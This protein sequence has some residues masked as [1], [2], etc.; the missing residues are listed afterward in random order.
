[1]S[2]IYEYECVNRIKSL[3]QSIESATGK[4]YSDLTSAIQGLKDS[5]GN[6]E[7]FVVFN[8]DLGDVVL[9]DDGTVMGLAS[10]G[11]RAGAFAECYVGNV[12]IPEGINTIPMWCFYNTQFHS[13]TTVILPNSLRTIKKEAFLDSRMKNITIPEGVTNI[14]ER[15]FYGCALLQ[16]IVI[17]ASVTTIEEDAFGFCPKLSTVTFNSTPTISPYLFAG[18]G[19]LTTIN[20]PWAEGAVAN[21]PWGATK[22]TINYN[23]TGE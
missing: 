6:L 4:T 14:G 13:D 2:N 7:D 21:A 3:K 5:G 8:A 10:N 1:M 20:V 9:S 15:A 17:P 23:Y 18:C 12:T 16:S 22:A 19:Q 11:L